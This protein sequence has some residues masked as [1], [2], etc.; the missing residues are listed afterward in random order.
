M[1]IKYRSI[2]FKPSTTVAGLI[3]KRTIAKNRLDL[4]ISRIWCIW[5]SLCADYSAFYLSSGS[6]GFSW[7]QLSLDVDMFSMWS[8]QQA[9]CLLVWGFMDEAII[10]CQHVFVLMAVIGK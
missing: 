1:P 6:L 2:A 3:N 8:I 4:D 10:E 7:M 9:T 5:L